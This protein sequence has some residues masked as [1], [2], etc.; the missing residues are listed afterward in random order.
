MRFGGHANV[1]GHADDANVHGHAD[2]A[3]VHGHA[4]DANGARERAQFSRFCRTAS[5]TSIVRFS[6]MLRVGLDSRWRWHIFTSCSP[7]RRQRSSQEL[8]VQS[9]QEEV[10]SPTFD[11][12][13]TSST[14][15]LF[16]RQLQEECWCSHQQPHPTSSSEQPL[17]P[18]SFGE[19]PAP[20]TRAFLV[21]SQSLLSVLLTQ[22]Q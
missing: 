6:R 3:N 19:Q 12:A 2:D 8:V 15:P 16:F 10:S 18:L 4:D 5:A 13:S 14:E 9:V 7:R 11:A 1:H 22:L 17:L 21:A 20:S